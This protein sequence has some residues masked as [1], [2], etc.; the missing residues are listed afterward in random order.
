MNKNWLNDKYNVLYLGK[1]ELTSSIPKNCDLYFGDIKETGFKIRTFELENDEV[2]N[3]YLIIK[4]KK[5]LDEYS[6]EEILK[7][8]IDDNSVY[9]NNYVNS[10]HAIKCSI[11]DSVL[12]CGSFIFWMICNFNNDYSLYANLRRH[13]VLLKRIGDYL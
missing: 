10:P 11:D 1:E 4:N 9:V 2:F 3:G 5:I 8:P 7:L 13:R 12:Y 6:I